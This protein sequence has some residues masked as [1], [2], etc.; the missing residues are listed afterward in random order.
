M[1]VLG[2]PTTKDLQKKL[3]FIS[4]TINTIEGI[5][6]SVQRTIKANS[7]ALTDLLLTIRRIEKKLEVDKSSFYFSKIKIENIIIEGR[8]EKI[9]MNEF[10]F[11]DA[12][13]EA[14][15]KNGQLA[16]IENPRAET[17]RPGIVTAEI[18]NENTA[19]FT[20]VEGSVSEATA[21]LCKVIADADLDVGEV[22]EIEVVGSVTVTPGEA[23]T[24]TLTLGEPQDKP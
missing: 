22:R 5:A 9:T 17:D 18:I 4:G 23:E 1:G 15:K 21:V 11:V 13:F 16:K 6:R 20:A 12:T 7:I 3:D 10:Q 14:R 2:L 19:R 8:I 24:L